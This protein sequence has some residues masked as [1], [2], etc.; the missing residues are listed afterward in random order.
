MIE[1]RDSCS[2]DSCSMPNGHT[3]SNWAPDSSCLWNLNYLDGDTSSKNFNHLKS[4]SADVDVYIIDTGVRLTHEEFGGRATTIGGISGTSHWHGT[5]CAATA[6]GNVCGASKGS[7]F[8]I[9]SA[10]GCYECGSQ[11]SDTA[12]EAVIEQM[13]KNRNTYG[14]SR[15]SVLSYV[16]FFVLFKCFFDFFVFGCQPVFVFNF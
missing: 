12:M 3:P 5:H 11:G 1:F 16:A 6:A 8:N 4:S 9:Y 10:M 7:N 15:R 2:T 14:S 13:E